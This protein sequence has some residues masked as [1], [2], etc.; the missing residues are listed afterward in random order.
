MLGIDLTR[1]SGKAFRRIIENP[2]AAITSFENLGRALTLPSGSREKMIAVTCAFTRLNSIIW[3]VCMIVVLMGFYLTCCWPCFNLA[4]IFIYFLC[5]CGLLRSSGRK[6]NARRSRPAAQSGGGDVSAAVLGEGV[7][8]GRE[9]DDDVDD[10]KGG[11]AQS[12][13]GRRSQNVGAKRR[14]AR[15]GLYGRYPG[16]PKEHSLAELWTEA[17]PGGGAAKGTSSTRQGRV[18]RRGT[19]YG[20]PVHHNLCAN[21]V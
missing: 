3:L 4:S 9:R 10:R 18:E 19:L 5:C 15:Q 17:E 20:A 14:G 13:G 2:V 16:L 12:V 7:G 8:G 11:S 1:P 6:R 21:R